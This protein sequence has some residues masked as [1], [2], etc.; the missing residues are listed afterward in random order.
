M[1]PILIG[2]FAALGVGVWAYD[3]SMKNTGNNT[4]SS[5]IAGAVAGV[6]SFIVTLTIVVFIDSALA[7]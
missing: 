1:S 7:N 5:V 2:L 6:I 3:K 4:R